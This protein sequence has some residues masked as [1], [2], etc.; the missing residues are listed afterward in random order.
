MPS[1]RVS[2]ASVLSVLATVLMNEADWRYFQAG[3]DRA[4]LVM[5][6][7]HGHEAHP[8]P[9]HRRRLVLTSTVDGFIRDPDQADVGEVYRVNPAVMPVADALARLV[10][11]GAEVAVPGGR[12]VFDACLEL[13]FDAFHLA[14]KR[15]AR[16]KGGVKI[17]TAC[18]DGARPEDVLAGH[19]LAPAETIALDPAARV[20]LVVHRRPT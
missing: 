9:P 4:G 6:G 14:R 16:L 19:G 18:Q 3:L 5:I 10:K 13:G 1:G 15:G 12:L 7:R 2:P 20:D 8:N 11:P 17:F